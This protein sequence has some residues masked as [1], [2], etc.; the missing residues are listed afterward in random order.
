MADD[1]LTLRDLNR[2]TLARQM[3]LE[4][5]SLPVTD[6]IERLGGMQAQLNSAPFVGVWTRLQDF[7][8]AQLAEAIER[9]A[10]M[11][12]TWLRAT[13]HLLT[14]ADYARFRT[15]LAPALAG[16]AD[17]IIERRG[18]QFD[19]E[20]VL[21]AA[22]RFIAEQPRT[23]AE[24]S[25]MLSALLPEED[26]GAM[27]YT[28][29]THL[30]LVQVPSPGGWSYPSQPAFALAEPWIGRTV[31]SEAR[32]RELALRYLAGFGPASPADMQTWSGLPKLKD[33]FE[34]SRPELRVFKTDGRREL[35][36]LPN[37]PLP[38]GDAPA[39]VRFLPE[40]DNLL[41][42]HSNRTRI[43]ADEHRSRV[44]LPGLRVAATILVDGFVQGVWSV[45]RAR[46]AA[47]LVIAPFGALSARDRDAL[48]AESER[49]VRFVEPEA[50]TYDVRF[51]K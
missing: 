29:R 38:G 46:K 18:V 48:A 9:R 24:I 44:Y 35:F 23:F 28:V 11:K 3:L 50:A 7:G 40:F 32:L 51:D 27:R 37:A 31:D 42:S 8:R 34:Q 25:A 43:L 39:P 49:L 33:L 6:A 41:L 1:L 17:S 2:A 45:E 19:R 36:D 26:V 10:V 30:P 22:R 20:A 4:R 13:L 16:A 12:A 21:A 47:T 15:T 5:T 14:A